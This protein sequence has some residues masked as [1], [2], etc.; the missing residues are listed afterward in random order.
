MNDPTDIPKPVKP[1]S[2]RTCWIIVAALLIVFVGFGVFAFLY[3]EDIGCNVVGVKVQGPIVTYGD[4]EGDGVGVASSED[5]ITDIKDADDKG[6][7]KAVLVEIDSP[8]G[9]PVASEELADAIKAIK[10]PNVGFI[11]EYGTSGAY[12]AASAADWLIASK[13]SDV[14]SIGITSSYIDYARQNTKEGITYNQLSTG[15]FKDMLDPDKPLT[16]EERTLV[17]RDL[18]LMNEQFIATVSE[19]RRLPVETVRAL[20]D[21]S[22]MLGEMAKEKGL[23]D[24][25]GGYEEAKKHLEKKIG[26]PP[27]V[28]WK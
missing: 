11:R 17:E 4:F 28:C 6:S 13:L 16:D 9:Y 15:K 26:E 27:E 21:G 5:I 7:I 25:I 2:C 10:K 19:N 23:I 8:G 1:K 3:G 22:S 18:K 12:W 14:G 24:Q 20:A